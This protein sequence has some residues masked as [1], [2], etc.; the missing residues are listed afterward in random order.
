MIYASR[1]TLILAL[2]AVLSQRSLG[3]PK[4]PKP[5]KGPTLRQ[6]LNPVFFLQVGNIDLDHEYWGRP[7][8][9]TMERPVYLVDAE[10]PGSDL[11]GQAAAALAAVSVVFAQ[12]DP[13][14]SAAALVHAR[15]L[16]QFGLMYPVTSYI[17]SSP[18]PL[19]HIPRPPPTHPLAQKLEWLAG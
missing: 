4:Y 16:F 9:M 11:V 10:H 12:E 7:E 18:Y 3:V 2:R 19:S 13:A 15:Q 8:D 14:Y 6:P 5:E 1:S 17:P